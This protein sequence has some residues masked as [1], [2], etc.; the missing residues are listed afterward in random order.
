MLGRLSLKKG[1]RA[2]LRTLPG[3]FTGSLMLLKCFC[4]TAAF[5]LSVLAVGTHIPV[6]PATV[7]EP[8]RKEGV[9]TRDTVTQRVSYLTTCLLAPS[10]MHAADAAAQLNGLGASGS[11]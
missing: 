9:G 7:A 8:I 6:A 5:I 1:W 11:A 4:R 2:Q 3:M 10:L